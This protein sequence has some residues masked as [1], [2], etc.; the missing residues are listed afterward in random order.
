MNPN[1]PSL[2]L[3]QGLAP[4]LIKNARALLA[5]ILISLGFGCSHPGTN[6]EASSNIPRAELTREIGAPRATAQQEAEIDALIEQL[7]FRDGKAQN[8][9]VLSP[10]VVDTSA[11][12]S[13]RF[14]A[15][16]EAFEKLAAFKDFAF[17]MLVEHRND[18]RQSLNFRNHSL[19]N[20]VGYACYLVI[21]NQLEDIPENY[22]EYGYQ[23]KGRDGK[24]HPKPYWTGSVFSDAGGLLKWLKANKDLSY[25][26]KQEQ[27]LRWL[28][29][30]EKVIGACDAESYFINVLPL[31]IQILKRRL[32]AGDNVSDELHKMQRI[33][34]ERD[35]ITIPADLLPNH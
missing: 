1:P 22:S 33:L 12:Y 29:A 26:R 25:P 2:P 13:Q 28:L 20:S 34:A 3:S 19:E 10:G 24:N 32:E 27:C 11:E 14:R 15:C 16:R 31:E 35:T 21:K 9:P 5:L 23:R 6:S 8:Q 7:V 18:E 30:K 17:P 4:S